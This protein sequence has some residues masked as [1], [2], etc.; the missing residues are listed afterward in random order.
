MVAEFSMLGRC[1]MR[2]LSQPRDPQRGAASGLALSTT[3]V[4]PPW[5]P[6][7]ASLE[8]VANRRMEKEE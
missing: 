5:N 6:R 3:E 1:F 2:R 7:V 4:F 8:A